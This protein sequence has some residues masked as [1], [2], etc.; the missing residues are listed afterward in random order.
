MGLFFSSLSMHK[1]GEKFFRCFTSPSLLCL[2]SA[3]TEGRVFYTSAFLCSYSLCINP[4]CIHVWD[5]V[6]SRTVLFDSPPRLL[7]CLVAEYVKHYFK[8]CIFCSP[9]L[10]NQYVQRRFVCT[11]VYTFASTNCGT[12]VQARANHGWRWSLRWI[13]MCGIFQ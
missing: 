1:R 11:C 6:C 2:H 10:G 13:L 9:H 12:G 5:I 4:P 7:W 8:V 3:D